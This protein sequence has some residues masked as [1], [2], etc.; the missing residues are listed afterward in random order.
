MRLL[1]VAVVVGVAVIG[2]RGRLPAAGDVG[3][4]LAGADLRWILLAG[5]LQFVSISALALQQRR[6]LHPLGAR[7]RRGHALAIVLAGTAL[8]ISVPA[9]PAVATTF[10]IRKYEQAGATREAAAATVIVS[11][12][13]SIGGLTLLYVGGGGAIV[14]TR[15]PAISLNW[16]PLVVVVVGLAAFTTV[17]VLAGRRWIS[18]PSPGGTDVTG[19]RASR[20]LRSVL[21]S[22]RDGWRVGAGFRVHDWTAAL[23]YTAIKW[24]ADLACLIAT[25]RALDLPVGIA[26]LTGV[27]LSVQIVRQVPLTPGGIGVIET[28]L[29]A[30]LI[31]AGTTDIGRA[32]AAVLIYRLLSCWL[33]IPVGGIAAVTLR[34]TRRQAADAHPA[35]HVTATTGA[36]ALDG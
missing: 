36:S 6:L 33:I 8:S 23:G 5:V 10:T 26:A 11:G 2:L 19:G 20:Y 12:L 15:D 22:A 18:R 35:E 32:A 1:V 28:A 24:L 13:A 9:G 17:A 25:V 21:N 16:Q 14:V 7:L 34:R 4:A 27:Y 29:A 3:S 31:A 30:G